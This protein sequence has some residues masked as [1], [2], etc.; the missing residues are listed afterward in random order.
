[1]ASCKIKV[2]WQGHYSFLF[3]P[4]FDSEAEDA[5]SLRLEEIDG[6]LMSNHQNYN[7]KVKNDRLKLM[8]S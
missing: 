5:S 7:S 2:E 6:E 4:V 3:N 8:S 1:M